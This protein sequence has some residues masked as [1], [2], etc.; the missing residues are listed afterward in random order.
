MCDTPHSN[1]ESHLVTA[2]KA[3]TRTHTG[4]LFRIASTGKKIAIDVIDMDFKMAVICRSYG[5]SF[6]TFRARRTQKDR[7]VH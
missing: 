5:N 7:V 6:A 1:A 3:I 4:P 2:R